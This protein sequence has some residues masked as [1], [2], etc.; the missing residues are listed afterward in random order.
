MH[1]RLSVLMHEL[2]L[3]ICTVFLSF[4]QHPCTHKNTQKHKMTS[5]LGTNGGDEAHSCHVCTAN[6]FDFLYVLVALLIHELQDM[7][8]DKHRMHKISQRSVHIKKRKNKTKCHPTSSKSAMISFSS[9]RH[10][11]PML[12]PSSSM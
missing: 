10:S 4:L 9:L 7:H 3:H 12:L 6:G 5:H 1:T 8:S 2:I 11:T